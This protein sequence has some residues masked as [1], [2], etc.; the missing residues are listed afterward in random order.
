MSSSCSTRMLPAGCVC[1]LW[2]YLS[3]YVLAGCTVRAETLLKNTRD[4]D[5][6][7][8]LPQSLQIT[9]LCLL[10]TEQRPR[11]FSTEKQAIA[12]SWCNT[13]YPSCCNNIS[14]LPSAGEWSQ[15]HAAFTQGIPFF[16]LRCKNILV[17]YHCDL[18]S[19]NIFLNKHGVF[20][21][22]VCQSVLQCAHFLH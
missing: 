16:V 2:P 4:V 22:S 6:P 7:L 17:L 15:T 1:C 19:Y 9:V 10:T 21:V 14:S 5:V 12:L 3:P 18:L 8:P 11:C 20:M 13:A